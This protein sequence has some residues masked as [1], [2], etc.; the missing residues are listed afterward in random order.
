MKLEIGHCSAQS[1]L[2]ASLGRLCVA[3]RSAERSNASLKATPEPCHDPRASNK[4]RDFC[5][6][7]A[8]YRGEVRPCTPE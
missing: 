2:R 7:L 1:L 4:S 3:T 8:A 6:S 5:C